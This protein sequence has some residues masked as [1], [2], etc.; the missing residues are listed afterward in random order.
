MANKKTINKKRNQ[1]PK[2]KSTRKKTRKKITKFQQ[3]ILR[4]INIKVLYGAIFA[5]AVFLIIASYA[6]FS[7]TLNVRIKFFDLVVSTDNGLFISLDGI[8]FSESVEVSLNSIITDLKKTYP[9][10]T[11]QWSTTGLWPVSTNGIKDSNSDK[12]SVFLGQVS[13]KRNL[14]EKRYLTTKAVSETVSRTSNVYIAFDVFLK[15]VSG[16][17]NNDNLYLDEGTSISFTQDVEEEIREEMTGIMNSMR[18]GMVIVGTVP[19]TADIDSIQNMK[20]NNRCSTLIYEPFSTLHSPMSI[21][22]AQQHGITLVDG[23]YSPTYA[24]IKEGSRLEHANGQ[25]GSGIPLDT[26]HFALQRTIT[27]FN[28]SI[29][30]IPNG[31]TK[32]RV[33]VWIEGQDMD[34]LETSSK[35]ANIDI[36]ISFVKDL[37]GYD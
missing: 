19:T 22:N 3:R 23:V 34:S 21:E 27:N 11:N 36:V 24:I 32:L 15:N 35:G 12:F 1:N 29:Y 31:I 28:E 2:S 5:T 20:C 13:R 18:I 14:D 4:K 8:N 10:H 6:W 25:E 37:A 17:P 26:E 9:N 33:Y 16:S 30:S 7:A